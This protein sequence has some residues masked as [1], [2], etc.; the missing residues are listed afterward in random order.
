MTRLFSPQK[1]A[2]AER[3]KAIGRLCPTKRHGA[4]DR[5]EGPR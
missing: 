1:A 5:S 2:A 3:D 4:R